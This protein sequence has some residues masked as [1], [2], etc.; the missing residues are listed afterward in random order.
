MSATEA[1]AVGAG[2]GLTSL[3]RGVEQI[4][5]GVATPYQT[6]AL[7]ARIAEGDPP[8]QAELDAV[9]TDTQQFEQDLQGQRELYSSVEEA[10]PIASTAGEITGVAAPMLI[11]GGAIAKIPSVGGRFAAGATLGATE[12]GLM[13]VAPDQSRVTNMLLGAAIG[14]P[15]EAFAPIVISSSFNAL[16][17]LTGK[18][19]PNPNMIDIDTG[20]FTPEFVEYMEKEGIDPQA[21]SQ[22]I[23][24]EA[25]L[26]TAKTDEAANLA[27]LKQA[28]V[29]APPKYMITQEGL[30]YSNMKSLLEQP[31]TPEGA[32]VNRALVE[33]NEN[34]KDKADM[35][36]NQLDPDIANKYTSEASLAGLSD[37]RTNLGRDL[38]DVLVADESLRK[39][40]IGQMYEDAAIMNGAQIPISQEAIVDSFA[41]I[42]IGFDL[43]LNHPISKSLQ[44]Y[45]VIPSSNKEA[46]IRKLKAMG[47]S[48]KKALEKLNNIKPLTV[49]TSEE[50]LQSIKSKIKPDE[51]HAYKPL[52][53]AVESARDDVAELAQFPVVVR[54]QLLAARKQ[55]SELKSDYSAKDMI[56]KLTTFKDI[57][58]ETPQVPASAVYDQ[59]IKRGGKTDIDTLNKLKRITLKSKD[60]EKAW[61]QL[62]AGV[63][64]EMLA[65]SQKGGKRGGMKQFNAQ[66]F[67]TEFDSLGG[68]ILKTLYSPKELSEMKAVR[69]A[70]RLTQAETGVTTPSGEKTQ[71]AI[72]KLGKLIQRLTPR[73]SATGQAVSKGVDVGSEKAQ[74]I[75]R[76]AMAKDVLKPD[77]KNLSP[78]EAEYL[79]GLSPEA[80]RI[81]LH[82]T[83]VLRSG[84][85]AGAVNRVNE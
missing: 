79:G 58:G 29:K 30:D 3:G 55:W 20:S 85:V 2:R 82:G 40:Q 60:G 47:I 34:L 5:R 54:D 32:A 70:L 28:G 31:D 13:E 63:F 38:R 12:G 18:V 8:A 41:D 56:D 23:V 15:M 57:K 53:E 33:V 48:E 62:R 51:Y 43:P 39:Y 45:G 14:G 68:D 35:I 81:I 59:I 19:P 27:I 52:L 65:K 46:D 42:A 67:I 69:G 73:F 37:I 61:N 17:R 7:Q 21:L 25:Q 83:N 78:S 71:D 24:K 36:L 66:N 49:S 1:F 75:V 80:L 9:T 74:G 11:P 4:Y 44:E 22:E 10:H 72:E 64:A 76:K 26:S 50:L 16:K 77:L 6:A 84:A